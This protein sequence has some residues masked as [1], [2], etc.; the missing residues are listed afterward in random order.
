MKEEKI[1]KTMK[2]LE[3][4][5]YKRDVIETFGDCIEFLAL[6]IAI[7]CDPKIKKENIDRLSHVFDNYDEEDKNHAQIVCD[8]ITDL[9][10]EFENK[11]DD[12]LGE[13][14]MRIVNEYGK[15]KLCQFF[16]PYHVSL[17]MSKMT[18]DYDDKNKKL[19]TIADPCCGS[20][21]L[22]IAAL[23]VLQ[24]R[25]I[26]YLQKAL[27]VANDVDKTCV[28]MTYLQLSFAG[29]AA[30]VKHQDTLTQETWDT[31]R[32]L[33]YYLQQKQYREEMA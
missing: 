22:C 3:S 1:K 5:K 24:E 33:G 29:A 23:E 28:Y 15:P 18:L 13:L 30:I 14:Y 31:F 20:G 16:T 26:N 7:G 2:S 19:I 21:G 4:F 9:L 12:Y 32:T 27:I 10:L 11:R 8:E 6:K 17:L 25:K